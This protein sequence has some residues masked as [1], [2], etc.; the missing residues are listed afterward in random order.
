M[1]HRYIAPASIAHETSAANLHKIAAL[2][3]H[4]ATLCNDAAIL[5]DRVFR[6]NGSAVGVIVDVIRVKREIG[7]ALENA[8]GRAG[9][10]SDDIDPNGVRGL[11]DLEYFLDQQ[12]A[13]IDACGGATELRAVAASL[14]IVVTSATDRARELEDT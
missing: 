2:C 12:R 11:C 10:L 9:Q 4:A 3:A 13:I 14:R 5:A 8:A 6:A 1:T 7:Q